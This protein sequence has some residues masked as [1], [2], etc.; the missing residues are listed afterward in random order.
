MV[1]SIEDEISVKALMHEKDYCARKF[2]SEFPDKTWTLTDLSY[3]HFKKKI[4]A[5]YSVKKRQSSG[6]Q[7][8]VS[9]SENIES[10]QELVLSQISQ[11]G[12][13]QS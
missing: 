2:V 3:I 13:D 8:M 7:R 10:L 6:T 5:T 4:E 11:P 1:L 12:T 9:I